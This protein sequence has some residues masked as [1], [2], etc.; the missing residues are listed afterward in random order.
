M[1]EQAL[2][3]LFKD[4]ITAFEHCDLKAARA[5]YHLPCTLHT[6]DKIAY[7]VNSESFN[8]EFKD[9]FTVL[10][11]AKT[12]KIIPTSASYNYADNSSIDICVDWAFFDDKDQVFADF[13]AFF[14][15]VKV[16]EQFK[17]MSVVSHDLSNSIELALPLALVR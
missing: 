9:I 6:P 2:I 13:T 4:Y 1:L 12:R 7:L 11:H 3:K 8:Q 10:T 17:I 14:H 15:V 16:D 5:C